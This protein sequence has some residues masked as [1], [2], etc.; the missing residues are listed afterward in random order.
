MKGFNINKTKYITYI[1]EIITKGMANLYHVYSMSARENQNDKEENKEWEIERQDARMR[2]KIWKIERQC[3]R[4]RGRIS[5]SEPTCGY[6]CVKWIY[7]SPG[8]LHRWRHYKSASEISN[9]FI[10]FF[11]L[12]WPIISVPLGVGVVFRLAPGFQLGFTSKD[13]QIHRQRALY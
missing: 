9:P 2:G 12:A 1:L 8:R 3:V 7:M 5:K 13:V 10:F 6:L 4:M 11:K